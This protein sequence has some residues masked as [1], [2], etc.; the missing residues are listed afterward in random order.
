MRQI[1]IQYSSMSAEGKSEAVRTEKLTLAEVKDHLKRI[2]KFF[3]YRCGMIVGTASDASDANKASEDADPWLD[4]QILFPPHDTLKEA[5]KWFRAMTPSPCEAV[6]VAILQMIERKVSTVIVQQNLSILT[7][8]LDRVH[9]RVSC[10]ISDG[11]Y[12]KKFQVEYDANLFLGM[13]LGKMLHQADDDGKVEVSEIAEVAEATEMTKVVKVADI[14]QKRIREILSGTLKIA[15]IYKIQYTDK[16]SSTFEKEVKSADSAD[17]QTK[18][19]SI[20]KE[21]NEIADGKKMYDMHEIPDHLTSGSLVT[22]T[23]VK[24]EPCA[25]RLYRW[26]DNCMMIIDE[27]SSM[28][29]CMNDNF[30]ALRLQN[31]NQY[32][33]P[34]W[35]SV[36]L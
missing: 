9:D 23:V 15:I 27:G 2:D 29:M 11:S 36:L 5:E 1:T 30:S 18:F 24:C 16:S 28:R 20:L 12:G 21:I 33:I 31:Y 4:L 10:S 17:M 32:E 3:D 19:V 35:K 34:N 6:S 22:S 13:F 14:H 7:I 25:I 26:F 8:K